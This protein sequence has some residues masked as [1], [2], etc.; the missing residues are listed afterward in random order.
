MLENSVVSK[1]RRFRKA[2]AYVICVSMLFSFMPPSKVA[3]ADEIMPLNVFYEDFNDG[4]ADSW[5]MYGSAEAGNRGV[6]AVNSSQ[7][8]SINGAPGAKTIASSN[9]FQ[10][11]V[12]EVDL[13][14]GGLNSDS[15]GVLFRANNLTDNVADGY[16]GYYASLTVDKKVAL[17]RVTGNGDEWKELAVVPVSSNQGHFKVV[18]VGNHIQIYLN[19]MSTPVIDF[20]DD[21]GK[22]ITEGGQIGLRTWWGTSTIDNIIVREY[23]EQATFAPEFSI[24]AGHYESMQMVSLTSNTPDAMIRY[25]IDGSQ[26]NSSSPIYTAPITVTSVTGIKAYAEKAGEMVSDTVEALYVIARVESEWKNDFE[27]GE[28]DE[29]TLYTGVQTGVWTAVDG[30]Y[31]VQNGRGDKALLNVDAEHF[32][33]EAHINP[34][35]SW[36]NSGFVFRVTDPGHGSDNMNGYYAGIASD[37]TLEVGKMNSTDNNGDGSWTGIT[38]TF[39]GVIPNQNNHLKVVGIDTTYYIYVNGKLSLQFTDADYTTGTVG[40]RAWNDNE[41]VTYDNFHFTGLT[42]KTGTFT[43][44]F[45]DGDAS[46][47]TTFDGAWNVSDGMYKVNKGSGFKAIASGTSYNNFTYEA[48]LSIGTGTRDENAGLLFRVSNPTIGADNLQGYYAGIGINGRVQVGKFNNNWTE[49]AS[50][51]YPISSNTVYKLKVVA[52]GRNIEVYVNGEIVVSVVDRS[53]TE[54]AIGLRNFLVDATYDN[55][56]VNDIGTVLQPTYNW[57]WVQGAVFVPTNAVNQIEQWRS[58]DHEI[59][60]RELSYAK[61]YG[62]NLVRV[63][64]HN[65]LWEHDKDNLLANLEDFLS[66]ADKYDIK[67]EL[68]FFDDCWGDFPIWGDQPL[69]RY[70]A[71]NSR[72]VEAPGDAVKADYAANKEKLKQYVQG[73]V[74]AF[75]EDDRIAIWNVFNEPSNGESGL[76]DTVT[77]QIM[78][79]ARIW[80]KETGSTLPITS[81]GGQFSGGPFSDFI[82]Y[83]PYE[84]DYPTNPEKYG[85]NSEVLA[86]EVMNRLTQSVPGV[87]EN[88]GK[89]GMGFVMWELGIGR[90]NTRFPWGSDVNP[91]TEEPQVPFHGV[92]YPDGHPWDVND[93]KALVGDKYN[94]LP[95][96]NV[97]YFKDD[98]FAQL[99]KKSI[100]PRIDFD[101]GDEKGTGSVDPTVGIGEDHF[102]IRWS[103]TIQPVESGQYTIYADSDNIAKVWIDGT[104]VINKQSNVREEA[105]GVITLTGGEKLAV[106]IEYVHGT[107]DSSMHVKWAGPT[108]A[109]QV[110]LPIYTEI[111][112]DTVSITPIDVI[113][114]IGQTQQLLAAIEPVNASN[115][116]V[117]WSSSK[118]GIVQV[119]ADGLVKGIAEGTATI[120]A[121]STDG[122]KT[123]TTAVTVE[124]STMFTNPI[125]PVSSGAGSADPSIVFKDGYYYYVKSEN[126]TALVVA[127][128]KRLEDI[129]ASPRVTVYTPPA[130]TNYSKEIWAPELQYINGKWYIYFAADDGNNANHRMYALEGTTQDPQGT[131]TFKGKVTDATDKWS[132]DGAVLQADDHSLYFVWSGWEGDINERQNIYIASMSNPWTIN[133]PRV[134]ISTPEKP[135][136]LN[137]TPY[138]NEAPEILKKDGKVFIVY[139]ASGSWTDDYALGMLT[140]T[141]GN[142]LKASSWSKSGP[143]FSKVPTSFGPGHNT[144]TTSPDG[145]EDWIVY[146]ATLKSGASWGNRSVRAQKFT[147]NADGTPNFGIPVT[148]GSDVEQPSGTPI[149]ERYK[150]EAEDAELHGN[151]AIVNSDNSSG[152]KVVGK[153]DAVDND[154]MEF[155][156]D[157]AKAGDY[158][159]IVMAENGSANTAIAQH[160][161]IVNGQPTGVISYKNFGWNHINP[162][163]IDVTLKAG[164]NTIRM[165]KKTN[166]AQLDYIVL[167]RITDISQNILP[168]E[169]LSL[170]KSIMNLQVGAV[171][172]LTSTMKPIMVSD[173]TVIATTS[174]PNI[175]SV[176]LVST[177]SATGGAT[178]EVTALQPG[179]TKIR[180]VSAHNGAVIAESTVNVLHA[181]LEPDLSSFTVDQFDSSV[182]NNAWSIFQEQASHWSLMKNAD[183]M[184]IT[185]TATDLFQN[186]N[187]QNNVFLQ[188]VPVDSDFEI[189][190]KLTAPVAKNHQQAGLIVWQD[191]DN[192][193]KLNHVWAD[194]QVLETAYEINQQYRKPNNF[195]KH[196]G[197]DTLTLKLK[198][199]GTVYT[200]YYWDGYE[201]IKAAND[202]IADLKN[203]KVGFYA[204]NIVAAN[205]PIDAKFDYFAIRTIAGGVELAPQSATL[206]AGETVQLTN[207]GESKTAVNWSSSN[208]S[209]ATVS[210]L[211]LVTA[212]APGRAVITATS[213]NGDF[214]SQSIVTVQG[215]IISGEVLYSED[216]SN[217][218]ASDWSTYDGIWSFQD[219][220]Y[221][222]KN[223]EGYKAALNTQQFTDFVMETD[224]KIVSGTEAGLL[225][226]ASNL[227]VGSDALDGYYVGINAANK[228]AVL[229]VFTA[230]KWKEIA[231]RNLPI[232]TNQWYTIKVVVSENHIQVYINDNPLNVNP[233]PKFDLAET[234]HPATGSIGFRT[235]KAEAQFDNVKISSYVETI[236]EPT[237]TN[238]EQLPNIADPHVMFYEGMYYLYGTHTADYPN[239]PNGIKVYTSTDLVN[240]TEHGYALE[241][242]NSWGSDRF[243]APEVIERDGIFYM[244]YAV[245]ERLAVATSNSP[246]GPFVQE[247]KEPM[248]LNTPEID[249]HIFT[250]DDGKTYIYFVRFNNNNHLLVAELND[251]MKTMKE[252]TIQFVFAPTQE[253]EKSQK[254]PVASINEGPFVIKHNDIYYMT[255]SG[256]HFQSPD[257]G[258]GYATAPTPT[259]PWTKYEFNPIMKSNE[260]VPGAGHHSLIQSPDGTE[261]FMVYHTHYGDGQ[262]EPRKLAIDRVKFVPQENGP[263]VM[264]VW[265]PTITPQRMPSNGTSVDVNSIILSGQGGA[266]AITTK[267]GTLQLSVTVLPNEATNKQVIWTIDN[268]AQFASI[269]DSG[270]LTALADGE[271]TV[272]ATAVSNA[273]VVS[274]IVITVSGQTEVVEPTPLTPTTPTTPTVPTPADTVKIEGNVLTVLDLKPD[275]NGFLMIQLAASDFNKLL[276]QAVDQSIIINVPNTASGNK[277]VL[278]LTAA[279]L[280]AAQSGVLNVKLVIGAKEFTMNA[281]SLS[282]QLNKGAEISLSVSNVNNDSLPAEVGKIVGTKPVYDLSLTID[283]VNVT[284][285]GGEPIKAAIDYKLQSNENPNQVVVYYINDNGDLELM[286]RAKYNAA[287]GK[288]EFE[289]T[290][291]GR[292]TALNNTVTFTDISNIAW[293]QASIE[294]LAARGIVNGVGNELFSP[295]SNVTRAQ[296]ITMLMNAFEFTDTGAVSSFSDV[297]DGTWYYDAVALAQKLGISKGKLDGSFGVQ[298][299]I[300]REEMAVMAYRAS[301]LANV[302]LGT[303]GIVTPFA[304]QSSIADY[305]VEGINAMQGAAIVNGK[306]ADRFAPKDHATRAEA[307]KIIYSLFMLLP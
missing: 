16:T 29:W 274:S 96:F 244:Y 181:P 17:G 188:N 178:F 31:E 266:S 288:A 104:Q 247:V 234:S 58:Y 70:G 277:V 88:F 110:M 77:K 284:A 64:M 49:L 98:N 15:T 21:D 85:P 237:Y 285:F 151:A 286:K 61:T 137:G 76:M 201:W 260:L 302:T 194:G 272:K 43:D 115:Q 187:S 169:S 22:Q 248:H 59:N 191:A 174:N 164:S 300:T 177:D 55:I 161:V 30:R 227:A 223:G 206:Q 211:G 273:T 198:K 3:A 185:T 33:V 39:A 89:Q 276:S 122:G 182:L 179:T 119:S 123:A 166:F 52:E 106:K 129:G 253:W 60:D 34:Y 235:F 173:K 189:V 118:P 82:T 111:P 139:S 242:A 120:T 170:D 124:K 37:G 138:I 7:Q 267:G 152:G 261:L 220:A 224:V 125:V 236:T 195:V 279:Q 172:A 197:G 44:N 159:L 243:W 97:H 199:M 1:G 18:A 113:V 63:F 114:K 268:G 73:V 92:V 202:V 180:V 86:D 19:D 238:L 136:E 262:T 258:V 207:T 36:Q 6:W 167:D 165:T 282:K 9:F 163:S 25:T 214:S 183:F 184:T 103:G 271:V 149:V 67:V 209:I 283:G 68:V 130:G 135:W 87:V 204:N 20:V 263:D 41:K 160:N 290:Q 105:S 219:G 2:L 12:Y 303:N 91:L 140:N 42:R 292:Y 121:I 250:D 210:N 269:S 72:W 212:I 176:K 175:A 26:P 4:N 256:N 226:R 249:A 186:N 155:T 280:A 305:A 307:A 145:T 109:K 45:D 289:A 203:I 275:A 8:Y 53:Y 255:Y 168:I 158:S 293:A 190:T 141:D 241:K 281:A 222:V 50:I 142:F 228:A 143:L 251:D 117:T 32:V 108:M 150:Y 147:W 102:S 54:G 79:D 46:K 301:K 74:N 27:D 78:N 144:F 233:Y 154:F 23:S 294:A 196:P 257:Y 127:K 71:H 126:D 83:H 14:V 69:P 229:G 131:Y 133:G 156:V 112:V 231:T 132:I 296:F 200:T 254:Q 171:A 99:V 56:I 278:T 205:D 216:F 306:A 299:E 291:S 47:W 221:T 35:S 65:L 146:H 239:M 157:V 298:D 259:G 213:I 245:Q 304:D 38:K 153:L 218:S 90:D 80:I 264:E 100:T 246:L 13:K 270:L 95:I 48:D 28:T 5:S 217:P 287:T 11:L 93:I 84:S 40:F 162:S 51:P 75:K 66:L 240:W 116:Q 134:L 148:Y 10:N 225:F 193:V 128:A 215:E 297:Q 208:E 232:Y 57:S 24:A 295:K 101:L 94:E 230:G 265:G 62:I 81:T 252:E 107:G 192:F